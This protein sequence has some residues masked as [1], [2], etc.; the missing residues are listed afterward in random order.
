MGLLRT[1]VQAVAIFRINYCNVLYMGL[2]MRLTW[3]LQQ[4][5]NVVARLV[6]GVSKFDHIA[7]VLSSFHWLSV[8]S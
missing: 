3:R 4:V 8:V 6:A 1:L 7:P 5:Q 2:S